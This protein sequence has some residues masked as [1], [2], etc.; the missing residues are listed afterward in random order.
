[1][2]TEALLAYAHFTAILALVVFISSMAALCRSEWLNGAAVQRL[3]RLASIADVAGMAVLITGVARMVWG[4]KG[5]DWYLAQPLL[6]LK[7][8]L[9]VVIG[10][11]SIRP[12]RQ[13]R[14]WVQAWQQR[15]ALP[16]EAAVRA[17]RRWI[18][19]QAH[20]LALVPLFAALLARGV[21]VR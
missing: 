21:W 8:T 15:Q 12:S 4:A 6:H 14:A 20:L 16:P 7:L 5:L 19:I 2:S 3:G 18:M 9:Y 13:F 1:M 10:L 11:M 17:V